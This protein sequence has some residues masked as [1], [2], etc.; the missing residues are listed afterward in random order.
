MPS[1]ITVALALLA[2][3]CGTDPSAGE[4]AAVTP[5]AAG[6]AFDPASAGT[7]AG[8]VTWDG[9]LPTVPTFPL[10]APAPAGFEHPAA[11][12]PN[13]PHVDPVTRA[14]AGAVVSLR[15]VD[16]AAARPWDH[17]PV[18]VEIGDAGIV[19]V[20]GDRRGRVGFVRA[21]DAFAAA[22]TSPRHQVLRGRGAAHFG[23]ALPEPDQPVYRTLMAAGRV[24]LS[25]GTGSYWARADLFAADHPYF[26]VTD[27]AGRFALDR[28]PTGRYEVVAWLPGWGVRRQDRDPDSV[29]YTR[30]TYTDP[31]ERVGPATVRPGLTAEVGLTV[32]AP[33]TN[34]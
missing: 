19:V 8:R 29:V 1:R 32:S 34:P 3:G 13:R 4:P 5:P 11:D 6:A 14:V 15:G 25:N 7:V 20:Q 17:P 26:T 9:P 24:E 30:M 33:R 16:S 21:G 28:V 18:R 10:L 22:S 2:A 27:A 23:L 31:V 12:N